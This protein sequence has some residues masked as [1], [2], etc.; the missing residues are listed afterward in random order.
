MRGVGRVIKQ[1][2]FAAPSPG[3]RRAAAVDLRLRLR[4]R[5]FTLPQTNTEPRIHP[6]CKVSSLHIALLGA[7]FIIVRKLFQSGGCRIKVWPS[8]L[9]GHSQEE[10]QV[11]LFSVRGDSWSYLCSTCMSQGR[12]EDRVL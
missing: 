3:S 12:I 5:C 9:S 4:S 10:D 7:A 8:R 6:P 1:R 11:L 2:T